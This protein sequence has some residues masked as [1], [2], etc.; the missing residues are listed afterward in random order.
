MR[1]ERES[2]GRKGEMREEESGEMR[3]GRE[4]D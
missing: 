4:D 3:K 1:E 2:D